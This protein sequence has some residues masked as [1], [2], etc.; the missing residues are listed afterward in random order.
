MEKSSAELAVDLDEK[1][2][3]ISEARRVMEEVHQSILNLRRQRIE[4]EVSSS[5]ARYNYDKLKIE[6]TLLANAFWQA[7]N[8][9]L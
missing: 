8:S 4:L 9:G 1:D 5:K 6:R 2:R 3:E 7:K